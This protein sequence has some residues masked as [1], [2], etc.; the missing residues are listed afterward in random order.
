MLEL[1]QITN[2]VCQISI[3]AGKYLRHEHLHFSSKAIEEKG[4]NDLVSFV[5]RKSESQ[6]ISELLNL[7][8]NSNIIAEESGTK[9]NESPYTWIIDPLDGTTN[10]VHGIPLFATSIALQY[11]SEIVAGVIHEPNLNETFYAWKG[12]G[13]WLNGKK[14]EVSNTNQL[15]E[16]L[17]ATGFPYSNFKNLNL[18]M[19]FITYTIEKTRGIRR[20]GSAAID[21]AY[22]A[23]GRLD[24]FFEYGLKPWD[25]AAGI[26]LV[27]EANGIVSDFSKNNNALYGQEIVACNSII[28]EEFFSVFSQIYGTNSIG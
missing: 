4:K 24:V 15:S 9:N 7:I 8:P 18:Y 12:G 17:I 14:I 20:L 11:E 28:Q 10:F 21:L 2:S 19:D 6:I 16:S 5:D 13:A 23:C 25:V 22:V 27:K 1:S 3:E 26:V